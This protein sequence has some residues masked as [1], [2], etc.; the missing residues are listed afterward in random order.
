MLNFTILGQ[1]ILGEKYMEIRKKNSCKNSGHHIPAAT[2]K[3][4]ARSSLGPI[5]FISSLFKYTRNLANTLQVIGATYLL[6][7]YN[8]E[9]DA[10]SV[11]DLLVRF[12]KDKEGSYFLID[13]VPPMTVDHKFVGP[14]LS[15]LTGKYS[16]LTTQVPM[17]YMSS[18]YPIHIPF[19]E[20]HI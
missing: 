20:L 8:P 1:P 5:I 4:S 2:A 17:L 3:G 7:N 18:A 6:D 9:Q 16:Y 10:K 15:H 13:E 12:M 19:D 14:D 11:N